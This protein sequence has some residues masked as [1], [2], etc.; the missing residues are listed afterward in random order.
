MTALYH[1]KKIYNMQQKFGDGRPFCVMH[2][3]W[4]VNLF[5][6]DMLDG[7]FEENFDG[8]GSDSGKKKISYKCLCLWKKISGS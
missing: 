8:S 3:F 7:L 2:L 6:N 5:V 4:R 1:I